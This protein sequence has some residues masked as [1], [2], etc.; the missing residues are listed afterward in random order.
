MAG[1]LIPDE[2]ILLTHFL[3]ADDVER[4]ARFYSA[5]ATDG[6]DGPFPAAA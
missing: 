4:S 5:T 6:E 1:L 2:G 3:T